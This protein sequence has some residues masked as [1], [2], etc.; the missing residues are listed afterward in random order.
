MIQHMNNKTLHI[1]ANEFTRHIPHP[2]DWWD[3][4]LDI[5]EHYCLAS[6]KNQTN[7]NF[8]LLMTLNWVPDKYQLRIRKI[9]ENSG[10]NFIIRNY[11]TTTIS[12][13]LS[14]V[15]NKYDFVYHT[16][17]DSDDMFHKDAISEIQSYEFSH[18]QALIFQKGYCYDCRVNRLQ[19]YF[20]PSPP[21]STIMYPMNVYLDEKKQEEYK[22]FK[23]HDALLG[24]MPHT[25]LSENKFIVNVHGTNRVTIYQNDRTIFKG[26]EKE[27]EIPA[28][29]IDTILKNF[30]ILSTTYSNISK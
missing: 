7:K 14:N 27:T 19:H 26:H 8:I 6:I 5:Y 2:D 29:E 10:L 18:R 12:E 20:M 24:A 11:A 30:G 23:S 16:R 22:S 3:R 21:F 25:K 9:L 15:S 4:R 17:V 28:L 1:I 13:A